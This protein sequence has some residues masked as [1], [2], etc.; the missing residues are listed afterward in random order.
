MR[1]KNWPILSLLLL[2]LLL[3]CAWSNFVSKLSRLAWLSP[4]LS[5]VFHLTGY[6]SLTRTKTYKLLC[7]P[8][9]ARMR[10]YTNLYWTS[11]HA[12]QLHRNQFMTIIR[13][14]NIFSLINRHVTFS[15]VMCV[16]FSSRRKR[17]F[18]T[19]T[20]PAQSTLFR[21]HWLRRSL[22]VWALGMTLSLIQWTGKRGLQIEKRISKEEITLRWM[23]YA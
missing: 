16:C 20:D 18:V 3:F 1:V 10:S 6:I 17:V 12:S 11:C 13:G 23:I 22:K 14:P 5:L 21:N 8:L 7:E 9:P 2:L 19:S 15:A 4:L